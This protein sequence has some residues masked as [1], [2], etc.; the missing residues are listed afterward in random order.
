MSHTSGEGQ[1]LQGAGCGILARVHKRLIYWR[2]G[3]G[4]GSQK[5]WSREKRGKRT[6]L[7]FICW[8]GERERLKSRA[9]G[10]KVS[11]GQ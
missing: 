8:E 10:E 11:T 4:E 6:A 5:G 9:T 3:E 1:S 2:H 7:F